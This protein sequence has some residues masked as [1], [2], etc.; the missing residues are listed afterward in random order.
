MTL[1]KLVLLVVMFIWHKN[2]QHNFKNGKNSLKIGFND[3]FPM[4]T[5]FIFVFSAP[6]E[7]DSSEDTDST[8]EDDKDE[9][10]D[11]ETESNEETKTSSHDHDEE[12]D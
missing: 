5:G 8:E 1:Y 7:D 11:E 2:Y 3:L 6:V 10:E 9:A 12:E 4:F